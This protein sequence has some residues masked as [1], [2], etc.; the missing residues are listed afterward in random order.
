MAEEATALTPPTAASTADSAGA[1]SSPPAQSAASRPDYIP[2]PLWDAEKNA[3]KADFAKDYAELTA[4]RTERETRAKD[5]PENGAYKFDLPQDFK[6]PDGVT[7][8]APAAS[9][10]EVTAFFGL[11]KELGLTQSQMTRLLGFEAQRRLA[12]FQN[13]QNAEATRATEMK[14]LGDNAGARVEA[15]ARWLN[16][17][18]S[19]AEAKT[20]SFATNMKDG[21]TAIEKII[22]ATKGVPMRGQSTGFVPVEE[23]P[24]EKRLRA[25]YPTQFQKSAARN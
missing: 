9:D 17:N 20:L 16:A 18:L 23:D 7:Y 1:S 5:I 11:G 3:P 21:V 6:L 12:A 10:P 2:E 24:Q 13:G 25:M 15:A 8:Q 22:E 19:E 14:A 4:L